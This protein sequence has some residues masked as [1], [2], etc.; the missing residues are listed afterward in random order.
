MSEPTK[1]ETL[2]RVLDGALSRAGDEPVEFDV[3]AGR[4]A[5]AAALKTRTAVGRR[6]GR[7]TRW[8]AAAAAVT[9]LT[10]AALAASTADF[11]SNPATAAEELVKAADLAARVV[12]QP[13]GPGQYRYVVRRHRGIGVVIG[14]NEA[15]TQGSRVEEWIPADH[16]QEWLERRTSEV[17]PRWVPG[18]EG[19]GDPDRAR[20]PEEFRAA[21]GM[22]SYYAAD[23]PDRCTVG[24]WNNPTPEFLASLPSEPKALYERMVADGGTGTSGALNSA[25]TALLTGRVP[26]D[27]RADVYRALALMPG[28]VI[29]EKRANI[30]GVEGVA[31]GAQYHEH[32]SEI[33]INPAD[34]AFI[35]TRETT[36][37]DGVLEKGTVVQAYS[38]TTAV[39]GS[40]GARP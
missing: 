32:F 29:T 8:I 33:I 28:L 7:R 3:A 23:Y 37:Q 15:S 13:V 24:G 30:D 20:G 16:R 36:A 14:G 39:V 19:E 2:D 10:G 17:E 40:L 6:P 9:V 1:P 11:G 21:C 34:G 22:F 12:D 25:G 4:A 27:V 31:L 38:L 26:A 5:L 35:G 18:H